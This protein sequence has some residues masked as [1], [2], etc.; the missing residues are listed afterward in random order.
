MGYY[1]AALMT[2]FKK[3]SFILYFLAGGDEAFDF[4]E[5]GSILNYFYEDL[6][7]FFICDLSIFLDF[8]RN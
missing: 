2:L 3:F 4:E 6:L 5:K 1:S 7:D 8:L